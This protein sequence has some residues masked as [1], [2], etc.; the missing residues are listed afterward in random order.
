[1]KHLKTYENNIF[2]GMQNKYWFLKGN[3]TEIRHL[4]MKFY[5]DK[6]YIEFKENIEYIVLYIFHNTIKYENLYGIFL[7]YNHKTWALELKFYPIFSEDEKNKIINTKD[8][9]VLGIRFNDYVY[10]GEIKLK[11]NKFVVD[12]LYIDVKKYNI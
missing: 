8:N 5:E 2:D 12:T 9:Y 1:M 3:E 10:Q 7:F 4:L 6:N 11:N